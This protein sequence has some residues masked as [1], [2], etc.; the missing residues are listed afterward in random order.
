PSDVP[1]SGLDQAQLDNLPVPAAHIEDIYP[2]SPMQQGM[3]FHASEDDQAD[4]YINQ[5]SVPVTGLEAERFVAAWQ[6]VVAHHPI[7][8]T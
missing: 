1:L 7:L 6:Q 8:R 4:L 2:L 3:L 5:T